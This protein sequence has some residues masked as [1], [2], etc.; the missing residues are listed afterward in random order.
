MSKGNSVPYSHGSHIKEEIAMKRSRVRWTFFEYV[1]ALILFAPLYFS[2]FNNT[3]ISLL[4]LSLP[5][6]W[7]GVNEYLLVSHK[8]QPGKR[9][10]LASELMACYEC[11]GSKDWE[12]TFELQGRKYRRVKMKAHPFSSHFLRSAAHKGDLFL[13]S[14]HKGELVMIKK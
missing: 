13:V 4:S 6:I 14:H 1:I 8:L 5:L 10:W 11:C 2:H 12:I 3:V 7:F 9:Y